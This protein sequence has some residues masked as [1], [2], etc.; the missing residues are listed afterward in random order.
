MSGPPDPQPFQWYATADRLPPTDMP[1]ACVILNRFMNADWSYSTVFMAHRTEKGSWR[2]GDSSYQEP[3]YWC[4]LSLPPL[5][6]CEA[7]R[8]A[9]AEG[10][11]LEALWEQINTLKAQ[12]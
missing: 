1:V 10:T 11:R 9:A 7:R 12:L 2:S 3:E 6:D 8:I 5:P 4:C